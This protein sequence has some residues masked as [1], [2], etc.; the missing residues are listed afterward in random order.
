[1]VRTNE[2]T[3]KR[4]SRYDFIRLKEK[5]SNRWLAWNDDIGMCLRFEDLTA[6]KSDIY[7]GTF[8]IISSFG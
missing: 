2:P 8:M 3:S 6:N 1:M 4:T 7:D 5:Q